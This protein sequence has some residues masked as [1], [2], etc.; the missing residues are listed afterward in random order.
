MHLK[1][2]FGYDVRNAVC[3]IYMSCHTNNN[4]ALLHYSNWEHRWMQA[5]SYVYV[6]M[7]S[8]LDVYIRER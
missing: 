8:L 4:I 7:P 3:I 5:M 6:F 1:S 2:K